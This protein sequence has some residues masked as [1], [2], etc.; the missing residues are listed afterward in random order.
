MWRKRIVF[1]PYL[2]VG[3]GGINSIIQRT[4]HLVSRKRRFSPYFVIMAMYYFN[5]IEGYLS[6]IKQIIWKI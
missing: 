5:I 4:S 2:N 6:S 1:D 3:V